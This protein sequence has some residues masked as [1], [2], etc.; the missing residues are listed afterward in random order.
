MKHYKRSQKI[1]IDREQFKDRFGTTRTYRIL[2]F[3][4]KIL[5]ILKKPNII[6]RLKVVFQSN[7]EIDDMVK[8]VRY[9]NK[10]R[11]VYLKSVVSGKIFAIDYCV[12]LLSFWDETM[13]NAEIKTLSLVSMD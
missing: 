12:F 9:T 10:G 13:L 4:R 1:F 11:Q 2:S 3:H 6:Y 7:R 5:S 8:V